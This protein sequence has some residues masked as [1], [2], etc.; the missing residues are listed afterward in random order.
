LRTENRE[1]GNHRDEYGDDDVAETGDG[2]IQPLAVDA[3]RAHLLVFDRINAGF[4]R[5]GAIQYSIG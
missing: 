4:D 3:A 1:A 2:C 5:A